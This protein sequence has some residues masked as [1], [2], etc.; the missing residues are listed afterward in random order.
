MHSFIFKRNRGL[1]LMVTLFCL[2]SLCHSSQLVKDQ[3]GL[4]S[5]SATA[6]L[7]DG[8][9]AP[10]DRLDV[11]VFDMPELTVHAQVSQTGDIPMPL[12]NAVRVAGLTSSEAA[13][14][15]TAALKDRALA[16]DPRVIVTLQQFASSFTVVGEVRNPGI[17]P[18]Y[19]KR[20]LVD[21]LSMAGGLTENAGRLIQVSG[22][23][24][25]GPRQ[26]VLWDPTLL[27]NRDA[28]L[29]LAPGDT[30]TVSRCGVVYVGGNVTRPGAYPICQSART[31]LS[32]TIA[33]A[34]GVRP[35]TSFKN[36]IL[37]RTTAGVRDIQH[38]P[39]DRILRGKDA[40]IVIQADDIIY[41]APSAVKAAVKRTVDVAIA[42]ASTASIYG[43]Q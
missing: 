16:R 36:T 37:I 23:V 8:P 4:T 15:I 13:Q 43:F 41:V 32:Q 20:R 31:T 42:F 17:Y 30:I 39:V 9:I 38:V 10:G 28:D 11:Q 1:S 33:L 35:S 12:L 6:G 22:A 24:V 40:D 25:G 18:F 27:D 14:A 3:A 7:G 2:G 5:A 19:G 34:Q 21:I 29:L 26:S